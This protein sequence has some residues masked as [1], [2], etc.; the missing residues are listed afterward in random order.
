MLYQTIKGK[1]KNRVYDTGVGGTEYKS[2]LNQAENQNKE[3][4]SKYKLS[5]Y[6]E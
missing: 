1:K 4:E 2:M 5:D 6:F 3:L